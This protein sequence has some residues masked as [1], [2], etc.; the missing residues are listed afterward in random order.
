MSAIKA[1]TFKPAKPAFR[2][3]CCECGDK[4]G[5]TDCEITA[6]SPHHCDRCHN[7]YLAEVAAQGEN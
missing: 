6:T 2:I 4:A 5:E 1:I 7:E 3:T